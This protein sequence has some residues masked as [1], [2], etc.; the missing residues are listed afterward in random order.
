MSGM[1]NL[2]SQELPN[3]TILP[4]LSLIMVVASIIIYYFYKER[5]IVK[6]IPSL[7]VGGIG[8]IIGIYA[9]SIFTKPR[10]LNIAWIAVFLGASAICG[11]LTCFIIDLVNSIKSDYKSIEEGRE[12]E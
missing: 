6:Y 3:L 8:I 4:I 5:K 12:N 9:I 10:G 1:I 7:I 2:I 11:I